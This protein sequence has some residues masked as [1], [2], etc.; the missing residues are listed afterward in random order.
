MLNADVLDALAV[1]ANERR[2][3][4]QRRYADDPRYSEACETCGAQAGSPCMTRSGYVTTRHASR[5][6]ASGH[7][8][9]GR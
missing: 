3:Q 1:I 5:R 8:R 2:A 7:S 6:R 9:R 4:V